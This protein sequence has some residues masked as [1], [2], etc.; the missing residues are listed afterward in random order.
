MRYYIDF[1]NKELKCWQPT[2]Q[3]FPEK[4]KAIRKMDELFFKQRGK[5]YR[6]IVVNKKIVAKRLNIV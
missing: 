3:S 5:S 4:N 6:I 2:G 1:Y